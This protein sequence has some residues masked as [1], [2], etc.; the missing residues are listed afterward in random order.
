MGRSVT[1]VELTGILQRV[2]Q[3]QDLSMGRPECVSFLESTL[4]HI[5]AALERGEMVKLARFGNFTVRA[6]QTRQGRN[7]KTGQSVLIEPRRVVT[8]KPSPILREHIEDGA[9]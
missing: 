4:E 8:F 9:E 3:A 5:V 6:K 2:A 7:P 1:R